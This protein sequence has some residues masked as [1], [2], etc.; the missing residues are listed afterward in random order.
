MRASVL[1]VLTGLFA[2]NAVWVPVAW[3]GRIASARVYVESGTV[4]TDVR[5][6]ELLDARTESTIDS[7][8][9]GTCVYSLRLESREG[10]TVVDRYLESSLRLDLWENVYLLTDADGTRR[11]SSLDAADS[12]WSNLERIE[13]IGRAA[14]AAQG[15]YRLVVRV[16]VR[17]LAAEDR[18]RMSRYVQK[19]SGSGAEELSLD[20]GALL[21]GMFGQG[22]G[23]QITRFEGEWFV[24]AQLEA[25]P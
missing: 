8:L 11:F 6:I 13:L 16:A 5:A 25:R 9:P 24:P 1:I 12:A 2:L 15:E 20:L 18:E 23:E 21:S 19:H 3:A 22:D 17:P 10:G 4:R 7:G 14:L